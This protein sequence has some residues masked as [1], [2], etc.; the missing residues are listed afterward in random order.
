MVH[1]ACR[2]SSVYY[3]LA[4]LST[5]TYPCIIVRNCSVVADRAFYRRPKTGRLLPQVVV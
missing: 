4:R 3:P 2:Y 1:L 5:M